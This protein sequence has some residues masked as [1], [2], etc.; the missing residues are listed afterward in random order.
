MAEEQKAGEWAPG[1]PAT[2][3]L[4]GVLHIGLFGYAISSD[5][6]SLAASLGLW[7]L[8]VSVP[9]LIL[10]VIEMRRGEVLFG[11]L[12]MVFGGLLGLGAGLS[13]LSTS[14][15]A[16]PPT[17]SGYWLVGTSFIFYL[18]LP[19]ARKVLPIL[20]PMFLDIAVALLLLGLS[21]AGFLGDEQWP[22]TVAGVLAL[23]FSLACYYLAMAQITNSAYGRKVMPF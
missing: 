22:Y 15:L 18:L 8:A 12:N 10:G 7:I 2:L 21:L 19:T 13:F 16:G 3:F 9:I 11:T 23:I 17:M 6:S 4:L 1:G 14:F 20:I 5:R